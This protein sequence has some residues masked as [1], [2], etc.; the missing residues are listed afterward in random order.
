ML[1]PDFL[2]VDAEN[3]AIELPQAA[4]I[5]GDAL[6]QSIAAASIIAKVTRDRMCVEW[7]EQYP[8]Y[9]IGCT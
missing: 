5:H 8:E 6:S 1:L 4:I 2:L 3:I 9:G 7:D